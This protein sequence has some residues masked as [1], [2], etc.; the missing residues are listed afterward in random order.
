MRA[1]REHGLSWRELIESS[2]QPL[3]PSAHDGLTTRLIEQA[4]FKVYQIGMSSVVGARFGW[5]DIELARFVENSSSV[6]EI[7]KRKAT[8][9]ARRSDVF[10]I[11]RTD[12]RAPPI[13]L[14]AALR[15]GDGY[16]DPPWSVIARG[17]RASKI[18]PSQRSTGRTGRDGVPESL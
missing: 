11:A 10:V 2:Q 14:G 7:D 6:H 8:L 16:L 18:N 1:E 9:G 3:R 4:R 13:G 12:A 15:R 17:L 5:N